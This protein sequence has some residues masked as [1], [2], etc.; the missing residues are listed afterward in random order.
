[1]NEP[2]V[3]TPRYE[4]PERR[5]GIRRPSNSLRP[6]SKTSFVSTKPGRRVVEQFR[7]EC[8]TALPERG[9]AGALRGSRGDDPR[10][11][12]GRKF[13]H[14]REGRS[15]EDESIAGMFAVVKVVF[16]L[17]LVGLA[18][19]FGL[20]RV[21]AKILGCQHHDDLRSRHR[22]DSAHVLL[23]VLGIPGAVL[24]MQSRQAWIALDQWV[25]C[26]CY[27]DAMADRTF[28]ARCWRETQMVAD[29]K[30]LSKVEP[31]S[32]LD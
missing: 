27:D 14:T 30:A 23:A 20:S 6:E 11:A 16:I 1:M 4:G 18:A 10:E 28:S 15:D 7:A 19:K 8:D 5:I 32:A 9:Q 17:A 24:M 3:N 31:A 2:W 13:W 26:L 22:A 21:L 12:S 25:H 29:D